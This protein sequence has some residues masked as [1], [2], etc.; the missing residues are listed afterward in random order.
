MGCKMDL[1][2]LHEYDEYLKFEAKV[3]NAKDNLELIDYYHSILFGL[4]GSRRK[5]ILSKNKD[6]ILSNIDNLLETVDRVKKFV[7]E[8]L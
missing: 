8:E 2:R 5:D 6:M 3:K 4:F 1:D 7:E